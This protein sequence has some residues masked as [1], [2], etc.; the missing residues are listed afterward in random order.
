MTIAERNDKMKR[1]IACLKCEVSGK[2]GKHCDDSCPTQYEAGNMGEI[3]ENLEAISGVLDKLS[4]TGKVDNMTDEKAI[5]ILKDIAERIR[6]GH[7]ENALFL[8]LND[9]QACDMGAKAIETINER[10]I[11]QLLLTKSIHE[12]RNT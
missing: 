3:I 2:I 1:Y 7:T 8:S 10:E 9:A 5:F 6:E 12:V 11:R 4:A